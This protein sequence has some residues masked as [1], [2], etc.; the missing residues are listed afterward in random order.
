MLRRQWPLIVLLTLLG[1]CL[2]VAIALAVWPRGDG[3]GS[4][5]PKLHPPSSSEERAAAG[6]A[7]AYLRALQRRDAAAACRIAGGAAAQR[8]H[9]DGRP[10]VPRDLAPPGGPL[11]AL[12]ADVGGASA[13]IDVSDRRCVNFLSLRRTGAQWRVTGHRCGGYA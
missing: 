2:A 5:G 13:G 11:E 1:S 10:R 6:V 3:V 9:C 7:I 8:L 4:S 12:S